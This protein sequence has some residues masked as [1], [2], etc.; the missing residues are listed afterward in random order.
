MALL[1]S[2]LWLSGIP[3]ACACVCVCVYHNLFIHSSVRAHLGCF[4]VLALVSSAAVNWNIYLLEWRLLSG[5]MLRGGIAGSFGNSVFS[6]LRNLHNV[7]SGGCT[8]W[9]SHQ[10]CRR[11]PFSPYPLQHLLFV[12]FLM[13]TISGVRW[14]LIVVLLCISLIISNDEHLFMCPLTICM[15][16]LEKCLFKSLHIFWL[17]CLV[18][19]ILNCMNCFNILEIKLL[20]VT[21]FA[22]IFSQSLGCFSF[23]YSFLCCTRACTF[24]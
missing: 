23:V 21:S 6:F 3:R 8:S 15:S 4:H 1:H 10:K 5:Y 22:K 20:L 18:F 16:S 14:Y 9:H 11:V 24:N 2:F 13:M 7:F 12:D 17:G 19:L